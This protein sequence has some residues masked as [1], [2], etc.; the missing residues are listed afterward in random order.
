MGKIDKKDTKI[1]DSIYYENEVQA[2][3]TTAI[4][5][6]FLYLL[7]VVIVILT[8]TDVLTYGRNAMMVLLIICTFS[9]L[10]PSIVSF[11][12]RGK[13]R[14]L[15]WI[16]LLLLSI[17]V[18]SAKALF[19]MS[20]DI[21]VLIPLIVAA[22]YYSR[23]FSI[24]VLIVTIILH[25]VSTYYSVIY[26]DYDFLYFDEFKEM[27]DY[28]EEEVQRE[29]EEL[30]EKLEEEEDSFDETLTDDTLDYDEEYDD[31]EYES[32]SYSAIFQSQILPAVVTYIIV[33]I[34]C[35]QIAGSGKNM[36]K[37]QSKLSEDKAKT[38]SELNIAKNIQNNILPSNYSIF[39]DHK[40]FDIYA[41]MI[42]AKE[43]GGDFYDMFLIDDNHLAVVIADVS[44][45][46]IPGALIMMTA[47]TLIKNTAL[48]GY[49][50]DEVFN[51]VNE[52]IC[53]GN[54]LSH[55][56]TSWLGIIDLTTGKLEFVNAG[57]NPPLL[58][59]KKDNSFEYL[60]TKP[61]LFLA[62]FEG[63]KYT[64][65]EITLNKDDK[66]FLYTDGVTEATNEKDE[67]YGEERLQKYLNKH[68]EDTPENTL[69]EVKKDI[70]KFV[71]NRE[72]FDDI[73]M[74][75]FLFKEK[76]GK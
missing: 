74:L 11:I 50:V 30:K 33:S 43:V 17:A 32:Y 22:R 64:K 61:N 51:R 28:D 13:G 21:I 5:M 73:T 19:L 56:V 39:K 57:H 40:E 45:K 71:G 18:A 34:G 10:I 75:E 44:G 7:L 42:P 54:N 12:L 67:L 9:L 59:S 58:Y 36:I 63:T 55:F 70:D 76:R 3:I 20:V 37:K 41:S 8:Y 24:L 26:K 60:K 46:G 14:W 49:S 69:K 62:G 65:Q 38:E 31:E 47:K 48:N 2:N 25:I 27:T 1:Q 16:L 66:L 52:R 6:L 68:I 53:E 72:Q 29:Y 35:N 15:K 23:S 4:A